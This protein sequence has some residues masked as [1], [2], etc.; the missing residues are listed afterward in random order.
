MT[1]RVT[2]AYLIGQHLSEPP[3]QACTIDRSIKAGSHERQITAT[4]FVTVGTVNALFSGVFDVGDDL[5][6]DEEA[7]GNLTASHD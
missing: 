7:G 3:V 5:F 1:Q 6:A 2:W 4:S